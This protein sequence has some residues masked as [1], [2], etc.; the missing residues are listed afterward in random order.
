MEAVPLSPDC[1]RVPWFE[2]VGSPEAGQFRGLAMSNTTAHILFGGQ[3]AY[4]AVGF[5]DGMNPAL[6]RAGSL[7]FWLSGA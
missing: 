4:T 2:G 6:T 1:C 7:L 3:I 5:L